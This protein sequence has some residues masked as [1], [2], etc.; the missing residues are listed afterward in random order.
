VGLR[1]RVVCAK[2]GA[3]TPIGVSRFYCIFDSIFVTYN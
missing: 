2:L 3:R 1:D